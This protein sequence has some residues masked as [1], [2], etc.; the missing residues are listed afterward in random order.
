VNTTEITLYQLVKGEKGIIKAI[1]SDTTTKER[2]ESLGLIEGV[3]ISALRSSP[4]GCP[5]IYRAL[6]TMVALRN[7]TAKQIAVEVKA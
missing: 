7:D 1:H 5:R 3:E 4:L 2:L 6:N